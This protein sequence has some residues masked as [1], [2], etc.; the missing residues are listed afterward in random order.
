MD[1]VISNIFIINS[2]FLESS[3]ILTLR[4]NDSNPFQVH[5]VWWPDLARQWRCHVTPEPLFQSC[6]QKNVVA[7]LLS[8]T[9]T[10]SPR[11][12]HCWFRIPL[13]LQISTSTPRSKRRV[14]L[15]KI[16]AL[17]PFSLF[18]SFHNL[19]AT[20]YLQISNDTVAI[21]QSGVELLSTKSKIILLT[22]SGIWREKAGRV[23]GLESEGWVLVYR[24]VWDGLG[25]GHWIR[26]RMMEETRPC[27]YLAKPCFM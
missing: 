25:K 24:V 7:S 18:F 17:F 22:R 6:L 1:F 10:S 4:D 2:T 26:D 12:P 19:K 14:N 9:F 27:R 15:T 8:F 3:N 23:E 16:M 11:W 5:G 20:Q 21:P 13:P